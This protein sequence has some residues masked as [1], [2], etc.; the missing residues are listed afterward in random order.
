MS[1]ITIRN[2]TNDRGALAGYG[3]EILVDGEPVKEL[4]NARLFMEIDSIVRLELEVL[5]SAL[6]IELTSD[7]IKTLPLNATVDFLLQQLIWKA[8]LPTCASKQE[9]AVAMCTCGAIEW[10]RNIRKL[11]DDLEALRE[12]KTRV[13]DADGR[14]DPKL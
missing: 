1:K 11:Q 14:T 3:V 2:N 13:E 8:H 9:P 4:V 10:N 6:D 12:S 5:P 7:V